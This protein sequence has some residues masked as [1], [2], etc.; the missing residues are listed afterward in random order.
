MAKRRSSTVRSQADAP[1]GAGGA[2]T[3]PSLP[4]EEWRATR[5]TLHMYTQV[6]GKLRLALSPPEP[7]WNHVPLYVTARGL[8]TSSMRVGNRTLDAEFDLLGH[9]LVV[10]RSDGLTERRP[11]GGAVADFYR[12]VMRMLSLMEVD[13]RISPKPQEV[14]DPILFPEDRVHDTYVHE[15]ATRFLETVAL[16]DAALKEHRARFRGRTTPV[17]FY[18]GTFDLAVIRYSGR[19]VQPPMD[20]GLIAR[21]GGDAEAICAGW[22]PGDERVRYPAFYAYGYPAPDGV[23]NSPVQPEAA[24]WSATVGEFL[25]PY[26]AVRAGG[27]PRGAVLAFAESTYAAAARLMS[28]DQSLSG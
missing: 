11:L 27:D 18:W 12:D 4:Y 1:N 5:D 22:W 7:Q 15:H 24:G 8:T 26:E 14:A 10:R 19:A 23:A 17:Q 9:E 16:V 28:W 2:A 6:V 3:W 25:M 13:V 20:R 21:V